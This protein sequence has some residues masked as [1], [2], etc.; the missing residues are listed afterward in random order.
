MCACVCGR[1]EGGTE[2]GRIVSKAHEFDGERR[3]LVKW[4][5]NT[6]AHI[7]LPTKST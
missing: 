6:F 1:G 5:R 2:R 4:E 7:I 3:K